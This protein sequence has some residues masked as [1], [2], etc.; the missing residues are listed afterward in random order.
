[1]IDVDSLTHF[2]NVIVS[3]SFCCLHGIMLVENYCSVVVADGSYNYNGGCIAANFTR[4]DAH[5]QCVW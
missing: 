1:M 2:V 5:S 3:F 4:K